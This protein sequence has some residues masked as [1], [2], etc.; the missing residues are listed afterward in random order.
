LSREKAKGS[1]LFRA[2]VASRPPFFSLT[3]R[4]CPIDAGVCYWLR[5]LSKY[6]GL[7]GVCLAGCRSTPAEVVVPV[8]ATPGPHAPSTHVIIQKDHRNLLR[9]AVG[10]SIEL[11]H[12]PDYVWSIRFENGS[13]FDDAP[14]SD[15]SIQRYRA[16]RTGIVQTK[17]DGDP[18]ACMNTDAACKI[19]KIEWSVNIAV[20]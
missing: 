8:D 10:D 2:L 5:V 14:A 3:F 13:Y 12:D 7:L 17:I 18:R 15:A 9:I 11:P 16:S 1:T 4:D 6:L 20:E 19:A